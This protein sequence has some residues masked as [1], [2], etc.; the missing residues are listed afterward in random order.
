MQQIDKVLEWLTTMGV[1]GPDT[2]Q[3][4]TEKKFELFLKLMLE[5]LTECAESGTSYSLF[6]YSRMLRDTS[7]LIDAKIKSN[8]VNGKVDFTEYRDAIADMTYILGN[9][10]K[11]A[12]LDNI[13]NEDPLY[14]EDFD[15]VTRSNFSKFCKTRQ[16]ADESQFIYEGEGIDTKVIRA[17]NFYVVLRASDDKVLKNRVNY[18]KPQLLDV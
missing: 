7:N 4:P 15:E 5:E 10:I 14:L 16:E 9:G 6:K 11:F 12:G 13:V 1:E 18:S 3:F 17:G 2:P 8:S